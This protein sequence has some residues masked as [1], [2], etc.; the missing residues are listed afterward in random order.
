MVEVSVDI[1]L[2]AFSTL[3]CISLINSISYAYVSLNEVQ[4]KVLVKSRPY[5]STF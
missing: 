3:S 1:R 4:V 2:H 5:T